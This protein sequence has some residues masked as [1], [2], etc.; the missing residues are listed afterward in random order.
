VACYRD[1][2]ARRLG[3]SFDDQWWEPQLELSLLA[4]FLQ[5]GWRQA[6]DATLPDESYAAR[7]FTRFELAWWSRHIRSA[8][9]WL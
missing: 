3:S 9:G 7:T 4:G 2:L 1:N 8:A 5:H 6:V